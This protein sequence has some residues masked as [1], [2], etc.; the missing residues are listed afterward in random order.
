MR[1]GI[2]HTLWKWKRPV[3]SINFAGGGWTPYL[4]PE[5]ARGFVLLH[6]RLAAVLL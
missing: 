3:I 4:S 2:S 6:K 5:K 1:S